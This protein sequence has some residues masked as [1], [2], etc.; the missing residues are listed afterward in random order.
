MKTTVD[1]PDDLL[2]AAGEMAR[3]LGWSLD[4]L[5]TEAVRDYVARHSSDRIS[6]TTD[7]ALEASPSADIDS[8]RGF[9]PGIDT[10]VPQE[11]DRT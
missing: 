10:A 5:C 6:G 9:L 1:I 7:L 2:A 8:M 4:R 3:R 11:D